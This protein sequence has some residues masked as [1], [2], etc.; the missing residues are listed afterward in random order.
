M[1]FVK[2]IHLWMF[3]F[4]NA[5]NQGGIYGGRLAENEKITFGIEKITA[6]MIL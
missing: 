2:L 6:N 4:L 1:Q 5:G 3:Y